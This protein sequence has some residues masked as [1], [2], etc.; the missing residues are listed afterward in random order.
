MLPCQQAM[1]LDEAL[2]FEKLI[3]TGKKGEVTTNTVS[4]D[5]AKHLQE[6]IQKLQAAAERL[7]LHNRSIIITKNQFIGLIIASLISYKFIEK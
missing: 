2:A 5:N 7:T 6:F 1:M 3:L 4:W